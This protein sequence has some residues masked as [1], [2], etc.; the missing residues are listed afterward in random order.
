MKITKNIIIIPLTLSVLLTACGSDTKIKTSSAAAP[1]ASTAASSF[2]E[3]I[4]KVMADTTK[5]PVYIESADDYDRNGQPEAF[6]VTVSAQDAKCDGGFCTGSLYFAASDL[7]VTRLEKDIPIEYDKSGPDPS[8]YQILRYSDRDLFVFNECGGTDIRSVI[9]S[10]SGNKAFSALDKNM[11]IGLQKTD[12]EHEIL[13]SVTD[14]DASV[15]EDGISSGRT[16]KTYWFY[17]KN[18][19]IYEYNGNEISVP[20]LKKID[21][22][23]AIIDDSCK[24]GWKI[25]NVLYRQNGIININYRHTYRSGAYDNKYDTLR[26][27]FDAQHHISGVKTDSSE[28]KTDNSGEY[29]AFQ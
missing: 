6:I 28:D 12:N 14:F 18:G 24:N 26:V 13:A 16:E 25:Q 3:K 9:Y 21:G 10:V 17:Y 2:R 15:D 22:A 4:S 7:T 29:K 19:K 23:A 11:Y 27:A 1:A 5:D 8:Y 20:D